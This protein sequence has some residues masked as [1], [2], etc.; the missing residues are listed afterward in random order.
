MNHREEGSLWRLAFDETLSPRPPERVAPLPGYAISLAR[1]P[2]SGSLFG[3]LREPTTGDSVVLELDRAFLKGLA[4]PKRQF[5]LRAWRDGLTNPRSDPRELPPSMEGVP[6]LGS[7]EIE[8]FDFL[9]FDS[10][11]SL[12]LGS[13]RASLVLKF[14]LDR[15]SGRY[16]VGLSAGVVE[17]G[18]LPPSIRMH[19]WRKSSF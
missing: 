4:A 15:P 5:S 8:D 12:Y 3:L 7:L 19:A 10:F 18:D 1:D 13:R 14:E 2:V 6:A 17:R 9:S 16:L 11:G